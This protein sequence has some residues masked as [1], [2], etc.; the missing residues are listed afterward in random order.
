[1]SNIKELARKLYYENCQCVHKY[2]NKELLWEDIVSEIELC[3]NN[4]QRIEGD[5]GLGRVHVI[6]TLEDEREACEGCY[7]SFY[8]PTKDGHYYKISEKYINDLRNLTEA[9]SDS[10]S[11]GGYSSERL[12]EA[13]DAK[14]ENIFK[15]LVEFKE[16]K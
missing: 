12:C 1:M 5:N 3:L 7:Y 11:I 9:R 2:I 15:Q 13:D 10:Y 8:S 14:D 4:L 6:D 16:I